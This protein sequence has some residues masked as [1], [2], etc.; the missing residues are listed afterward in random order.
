MA[1]QLRKSLEGKWDFREGTEAPNEWGVSPRFIE[2]GI[3]EGFLSWDQGDL[4]LTLESG[5]VRYKV[6]AEPGRFDD[7]NE[8]AG[9]RMDNFY[10]CR[11][12]A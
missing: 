12:E 9:Y 1:M 7:E 11:K 10:K 6:E 5:V 2:K 3:Q 4:V 8:P